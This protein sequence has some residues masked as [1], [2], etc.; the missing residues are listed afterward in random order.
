MKVKKD[1]DPKVRGQGLNSGS[2]AYSLGKT[3]PLNLSVLI[4][5]VGTITHMHPIGVVR[6]Q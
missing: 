1:L 5:M 2:T 6:V 4:F 3:T